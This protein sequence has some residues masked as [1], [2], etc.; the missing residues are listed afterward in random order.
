MNNMAR[1]MVLSPEAEFSLRRRRKMAKL[2]RV[3]Y[4]RSRK[5]YPVSELA[6]MAK[7][8]EIL[9]FDPDNIGG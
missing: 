5:E 7:G 8:T 6:Y 9:A 4:T 3:S 1:I 2:G